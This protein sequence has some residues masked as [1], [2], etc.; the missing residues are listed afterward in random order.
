MILVYTHHLW[1]NIVVTHVCTYHLTIWS[2]VWIP[3]LVTFC[4]MF[5]YINLPG[6]RPKYLQTFYPIHYLLLS[7]HEVGSFHRLPLIIVLLFH[8][9]CTWS[10]QFL[11][12]ILKKG[13]R[14]IVMQVWDEV[15][16]GAISVEVG[17]FPYLS[18]MRD[19]FCTQQYSCS[20]MSISLKIG[21]LQYLSKNH[22]DLWWDVTFIWHTSVRY[23][24]CISQYSYNCGITCLV[25]IFLFE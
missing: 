25:S 4:I 12:L 14:V 24:S 19:C 11:R 2:W 21:W 13:T 20:S 17:V 10:F 1:S 23:V 8:F 9:A 22:C 7:F 15:G 6:N 16:G 5:R 18:D 3:I